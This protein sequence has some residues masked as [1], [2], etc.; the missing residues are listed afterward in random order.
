MRPSLTNAPWVIAHRGFSSSYPENTLLAFEKALALPI[1]AIELDVQWTLDRKVVCFHDR[2]LTKLGLGRKTMRK[3]LFSTLQ[4]GDAGQWFDPK[5][6]GLKVPELETVLDRFALKTQIFIEIKRRHGLNRDLLEG[7]F[8]HVLDL[9]AAKQLHQQV[10]I[11]CFDED[12]L[13][14]GASQRPDFRFVLNQDRAQLRPRDDLFY[15]YDVRASGLTKE[16]VQAAQQR[17]KFVFT[18]TLNH[19][20]ALRKVLA[21]GVD[22]VMSDHPGWLFEQMKGQA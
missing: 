3:T 5:F 6:Q 19:L 1:Q 15:A 7:L 17:G 2:S 21:M 14:W 11:L 13:R 22:G 20:A 16:F 8:M 9:V 12:L 4:Q 10:A 18:F